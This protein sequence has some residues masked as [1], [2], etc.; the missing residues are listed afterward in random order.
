MDEIV[1]ADEE[2]SFQQTAG[3]LVKMLDRQSKM[4][5]TI[6][7][8]EQELRRLEGDIADANQRLSLTV[9]EDYPTKV[10]A[11]DAKTVLVVNYQ[12]GGKTHGTKTEVS[13]HVLPIMGQDFVE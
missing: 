12:S 1:N 4:E 13:I 2:R 9:D 6:R 5:A 11:V 8:S 3:K 10:F 7:E